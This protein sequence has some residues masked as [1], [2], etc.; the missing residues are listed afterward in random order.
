MK[1]FFEAVLNG[2][3]QGIVLTMMMWVVLRELRRVNAATK[4]AIWQVTLVV[5]VLLPALQR[6]PLTLSHEVLFQ[7]T[8]RA[9]VV[10]TPPARSMAAAP[11]APLP[12]VEQPTVMISDEHG[13]EILLVLSIGLAFFQLLRLTLGYIAVR[14]LKRHGQILEMEMPFQHSRP[15]VLRV[16]DSI[17][18]PVAV[19]YLCPAILLPRTLIES[20]TPEEIQ[21]VVLHESAHLHR[22]DDWMALGERVIRAVFCFQPAVHFIGRQIERERE[23]ACDDWV[24]EQSGDA[25]R[26]ARS[27]ARL[28]ELGSSGPV[29]LL[30]TGAGKR[31][32]IFARLE[33]LLDKTG[34]R[35]SLISGPLLISAGVILMLAV[36]QGAQFRRL[37]GIERFSNT[38][39]ESDGTNRFAVKMRGD[40]DF[41]RDDQDV[42]S[43]SPGAMLVVEQS[44]DWRTQRVE[45]EADDEGGIERRYFSGVTPRP[46]DTEARHFLATVLPQ[47]VREQGNNIPGHLARIV[48][49]KGVD[50]ALDDIRAIRGGSVKRA[51][52]EELLKQADLNTEQLQRVLKTARQMDSDEEKRDFF[53]SVRERYVNRG[54]DGQVLGFIDSINS[55]DDRGKLLT[56]WMERATPPDVWLPRWLRSVDTLQSEE[57]KT[58]V[59]RRAAQASKRPLPKRFFEVAT[60]LHSDELRARLLSAVLAVRGDDA[61]TLR[62]VLQIAASLPNEEQ[63]RVLEEAGRR[64]AGITRDRTAEDQD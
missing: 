12:R 47:W 41:S 26:Y 23:S 32:Q 57:I 34:N 5:V 22:K 2:W 50:G 55:E 25:R 64:A 56:D 14:R 20:L 30:A 38:W 46:F 21:H 62:R 54:L 8:H 24:V 58:D 18:M 42:R 39:V 33:M 52:L 19:G 17:G 15:V 10:A 59:L 28:A 45:F 51:N 7:E 49:E 16:S 3:W 4:A 29:P 40:V 60:S 36:S 1:T 9:S 48:E 44:R 35:M 53:N 63:R 11:E 61:G 43:M 37:F 27:L 6:V 13:P 31:T